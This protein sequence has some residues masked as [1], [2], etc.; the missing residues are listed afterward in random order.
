[1]DLETRDRFTALWGDYFPGA[2]LP[3]AFY[4]T[5][6]AEDDEAPDEH[7]C[8]VAQ[9]NA[10]RRGEP[11]CFSADSVVCSGGKRY[12]GF[13]QGL[14]NNFEYFLSCG[15]PGQLEGERYKKSPETV[16]ALMERMP[17]FVAPA[18]FVVVKRWDRLEERDEPSVVI[19]YAPPDVLSGLFTLA[20]F[21]ESDPN[22]VSAP[23]CAGCASIAMYPYLEGGKEHPKCF[24]GMFDVSA[25]PWVPRDTLTFAVPI[26]KFLGMVDDMT[27]SFLTR[28]SWA[29]VRN[30]L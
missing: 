6:S 15:I 23:F 19:F 29:R 21:D 24:L 27:E 22:A 5:E 26:G 16:K 8:F 18:P 4:Y 7:R 13:S 3:I 10:V 28:D 14:R 1:M 2:D 20:G 30:R 17:D 12:L 11:M 9:L 25:R